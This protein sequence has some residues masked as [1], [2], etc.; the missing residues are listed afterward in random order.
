MVAIPSPGAGEVLTRTLFLSIDPYMR[1]RMAGTQSYA[2]PVE[3]GGVM[4]GETVGVV[5]ASGDPRFAP[6]DHVVGARGWQTHSL[7]PAD[8]LVRVDPHILLEKA[9]SH[10]ARLVPFQA[11]GDWDG[12]IVREPDVL[13][14]A[15][16]AG[17]TYPDYKPAPFIVSST[18]EGVD[19]VTVVTEGIP[20]C[21]N[22]SETLALSSASGSLT[23]PAFS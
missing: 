1:G 4:E 14:T 5:M 7:W 9:V 18:V 13:V 22:V 16:G 15:I 17:T 3:I 2:R 12:T 23:M 6:G 10:G 21:V 8:R 19:M 20:D 11:G